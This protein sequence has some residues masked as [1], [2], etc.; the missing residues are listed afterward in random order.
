[1]SAPSLQDMLPQDNVVVLADGKS[2]VMSEMHVNAQAAIQRFYS[3]RL[4]AER[5]LNSPPVRP[6]S[7]LGV[8]PDGRSGLE[9]IITDLKDDS[10]VFRFV[11][12]QLLR[13][14]QRNLTEEDLGYLLTAE[15]LPKVAEHVLM[16]ILKAMPIPD[17]KKKE[18]MAVVAETLT[19]TGN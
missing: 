12:W 14:D 11:T 5:P 2:Y 4:N 15:L 18:I 7:L 16:S 9:I 10:E 3:D 19:N 6:F 17:S 13:R 1:M 8:G